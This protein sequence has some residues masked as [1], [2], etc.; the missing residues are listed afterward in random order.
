MPGKQPLT[1]PQVRGVAQIACGR[2]FTVL[3]LASGEVRACGSNSCG[4][5]GIGTAPVGEA[6]EERPSG[7]VHGD[8]TGRADSTSIPMQIMSGHHVIG[9]ACGAF[10]TLC[11]T[12]NRDIYRYVVNIQS[13]HD[14]PPAPFPG[15]VPGAASL[16]CTVST[17]APPR[18]GMPSLYTATGDMRKVLA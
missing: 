1:R 10:H 16:V 6:T 15:P 13:T 9:V 3:L 7:Q 14:T 2:N 8:N 18:H 11:L 4:Q 5:L 17:Q 12:V